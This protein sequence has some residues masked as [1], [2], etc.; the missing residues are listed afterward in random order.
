MFVF[1]QWVVLTRILQEKQIIK[2]DLKQGFESIQILYSVPKLLSPL[3]CRDQI[4]S[5]IDKVAVWTKASLYTCLVFVLHFPPETSWP[6][7]LA[8]CNGGMADLA[9]TTQ[10]RA[11]NP[12]CKMGI[13]TILSCIRGIPGKCVSNLQ[14]SASLGVH[15]EGQ[16]G[17][18]QTGYA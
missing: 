8:C 1:Y 15:Q 10:G 14:V 13:G 11:A 2:K 9:K 5:Q 3:N 7:N 6:R 18:L 12:N 17:R 16:A 4:T